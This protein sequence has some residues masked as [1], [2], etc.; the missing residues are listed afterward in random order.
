MQQNFIDALLGE[1]DVLHGDI[2]RIKSRGIRVSCPMRDLGYL[3][4]G[5]GV[6]RG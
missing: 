5:N 3:C 2:E 1:K 4:Q 6:Y